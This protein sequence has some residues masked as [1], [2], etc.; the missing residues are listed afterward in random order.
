MKVMQSLFR[1]AVQSDPV[2]AA[3]ADAQILHSAGPWR[4][5]TTLAVGGLNAVGFERTS[6]VMLVTSINGQSVIAGETGDVIYRNRDADGLDVAA[7]KGTRLDH[8]ADERFDMAGLFGGGLRRM[9]DDGWSIEA[10][11]GAAVIHPPD[12]SIHVLSPKWARHAKDA[13]FHLLEPAGE[14]LRVIGFSWTG[15]TAITATPSTLRIWGRPAP[16]TL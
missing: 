12:A 4:H 2:Q 3:L 13:T 15:R 1:G 14:E 16:L 9:T 8:P 6:E 5:V 7:L 11:H 10:V